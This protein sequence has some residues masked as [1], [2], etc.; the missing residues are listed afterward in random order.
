MVIWFFVFWLYHWHQQKE[1]HHLPEVITSCYLS[2]RYRYSY[3]LHKIWFITISKV[4]LSLVKWVQCHFSLS[5][6]ADCLQ[7]EKLRR[8]IGSFSHN[9]LSKLGIQILPDRRVCLAGKLLKG[10]MFPKNGALQ[11]IVMKK[12]LVWYYPCF[13]PAQDS[14][15]GNAVYKLNPTCLM[16]RESELLGIFKR[17]SGKQQLGIVPS[18]FYMPL[19]NTWTP[20][21]AI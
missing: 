10:V 16:Q 4:H 12:L 3:L 5:K 21:K 9:L 14:S 19:T 11:G 7:V 6:D 1:W 17:L 13:K 2:L 18:Y 15:T 8:N 20:I